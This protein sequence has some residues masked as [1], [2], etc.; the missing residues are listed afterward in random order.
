MTPTE[1]AQFAGRF[2]VVIE[3]LMERPG[4]VSTQLAAEA[5]AEFDKIDRPQMFSPLGDHRERAVPCSD[6]GRPTW[7]LRATCNTCLERD[8]QVAS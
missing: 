2:R 3:A 8:R 6:C 5:C 7:N 1:Y 4:E